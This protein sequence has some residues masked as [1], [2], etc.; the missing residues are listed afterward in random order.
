[1]STSTEAEPQTW[2]TTYLSMAVPAVA[3]WTA[4]T[5]HPTTP[6]VL[7]RSLRRPG[8]LGMPRARR[9]C[10]GDRPR[11]RTTRSS[12]R[13]G[14]SGESAE[15]EPEGVG[16]RPFGWQCRRAILWRISSW[17]SALETPGRDPWSVRELPFGA[18]R[19]RVI[20]CHAL[21]RA[22]AVES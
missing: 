7:P 15:S 1:M 21:E 3:G 17:L 18:W 13:S 11:G 16:P 4:G 2:S 5:P 6:N 8:R 12:A 20:L 14:D 22:E 10:L 9:T 19:L